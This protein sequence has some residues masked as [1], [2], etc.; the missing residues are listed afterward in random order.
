MRG[1]DP[2]NTLHSARRQLAQTASAPFDEGKFIATGTHIVIDAIAIY[3]LYTAINTPDVS[4]S[5]PA[6]RERPRFINLLIEGVLR[7]RLTQV[8]RRVLRPARESVASFTSVHNE[9][10]QKKLIRACS[11]PRSVPQVARRARRSLAPSP[12]SDGVMTGR[13][14]AQS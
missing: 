5:T 14:G 12:A 4:L 13:R 8:A 2:L 7:V 9:I 11:L 1:R 3:I 6:L 10:R